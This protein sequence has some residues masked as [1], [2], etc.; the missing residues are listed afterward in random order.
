MVSTTLRR[1]PRSVPHRTVCLGASAVDSVKQQTFL[2][3]GQL[4]QD[5]DL[6]DHCA[7]VRFGVGSALADPHQFR[8][9]P[10]PYWRG[11]QEGVRFLRKPLSVGKELSKFTKVFVVENLDALTMVLDIPRLLHDQVT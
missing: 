9:L 6:L 1:H 4:L 5:A 7:D 11:H 10:R 8:D 3:R 2:S